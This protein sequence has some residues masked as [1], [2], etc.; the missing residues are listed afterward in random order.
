[1]PETCMCEF[2]RY[3]GQGLMRTTLTELPSLL[4]A[5]TDL[6]EGHTCFGRPWMLLVLHIGTLKRC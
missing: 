4:S 2:L 3:L 5:P 1:M 6:Q